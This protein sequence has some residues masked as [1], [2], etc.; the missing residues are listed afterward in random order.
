MPNVKKC[1]VRRDNVRI[2]SNEVASQLRT[3]YCL[4]IQICN[5]HRK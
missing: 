3:R 2:T 5:V 4:D 1:E